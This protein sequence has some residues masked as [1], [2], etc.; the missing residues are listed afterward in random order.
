MTDDPQGVFKEKREVHIDRRTFTSGRGANPPVVQA[1]AGRTLGLHRTPLVGARGEQRGHVL[2]L[3]NLTALKLLE[4]QVQRAEQHAALGRLAGGLAHEIR[5]PLAITRAAAQMLQQRL[6]DTPKLHEYTAVMQPEMDR[7]DQ[8]I[9]QLLTYA[10]PQRIVHCAID[11]DAL[12]TRTMTLTQAYAAQHEVRMIS[13]V[14]PDVPSLEGD[15]ELLH[16][17]LVN[18]ILNSIQA[19]PPGG[20]ISISTQSLRDSEQTLLRFLVC[21][22]GPGIPEPDLSRVFDPFFTTRPDGTGLGLSIVQHIVQNHRGTVTVSN[23][24]EGGACVTV[25]LPLRQRKEEL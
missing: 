11:V 2:V 18:L 6:V 1:N 24:A 5:N 17:A 25:D 19:T 10:R 14:A 21:D 3:D 13:D 23:T 22:T 4:E 12:I 20:T 7:V 15:P 16:Q 8:L 9:E